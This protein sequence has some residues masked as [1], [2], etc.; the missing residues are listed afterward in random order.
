MSDT[1]IIAATHQPASNALL[2][3]D[4]AALLEITVNDYGNCWSLPCTRQSWAMLVAAA[5]MSGV[6]EGVAIDRAF[7]AYAAPSLDALRLPAAAKV[8]PSL[9][10][11]QFGLMAVVIIAA[12]T[13]NSLVIGH[14]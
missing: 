9:T 2:I 1:N 12:F 6:S 4:D 7:T 14:R 11:W 10:W 3:K 8:K 13:F 5:A